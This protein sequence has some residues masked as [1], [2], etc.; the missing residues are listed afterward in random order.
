[1]CGGESVKILAATLATLTLAFVLAVGGHDSA[2]ATT[3]NPSMLVTLSSSAPSA[4]ANITVDREVDSP[5]SRDARHISFIPG[6]FGVATDAA[7]PNGALVGQISLEDA[8]STSNS[9]CSNSSFLT[10][11]LM[12]ASTNTADTVADSP[13]IPSNSWPGFSDAN[14]NNL[15]DAVDKYPNFLK[16][17]YP[18][19][20]PRARAYASLPPAQAGINRVVNVLTFDPGTALPGMNIPASLGYIVV[21]VRQ[22]PTAPAATSTITDVCTFSRYT[23]QDNGITTN[24]P[25]TTPPEGGF[26]YR[27]NPAVDGTYPF[28]D[29]GQSA[30]DLDNDNIENPLDSCASVSTPA[31]TPRSADPLDDPDEDGIPGKDDPA[32]GEQLQAGT[33]CDTTPLTANSDHDGDGYLNRQ[34]NCPVVANGGGPD[35]QLDPDGDGIGSACDAVDSKADGHLHEV[36]L[37]DQEVIGSGGSP[38]TPTCPEFVPDMDNDGFTRVVELHVG[39]EHTDPCGQTAWPADLVSTGMSTNDIDIQDIGSYVAPIRRINTSPPSDPGFNVRWDLVPGSG[40]L[41]EHINI[42]DM[43]E[44]SMLYPPMLEGA[45]AFNGPAC[46]YAP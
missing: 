29:Y 41:G 46:P 4:N 16:V 3:F 22:D 34:D 14:S 32:A 15:P 12:D 2:G 24:N 20:T 26:V 30:R 9:P 17:I 45:R 38:T 23:R 7:I 10:Y 43:A 36:C 19:L 28:F 21:V 13:R 37:T 35:N 27:T 42:Q 5:Q 31:W 1:M 11:D 6:A 39:T 25:N 33:G 44:I 40:G 18:N 8:E